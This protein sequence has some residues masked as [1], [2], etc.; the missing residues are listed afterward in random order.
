MRH[1][2]RTLAF[3]LIFAAPAFAQVAPAP[4]SPAAS[5]PAAT[6]KSLRVAVIGASASAGFGCV[7]REKRADGDY[8]LGF[9]LI[10]MIRI[11]C[12]EL[13]LVTT[14][15]S[16][17][18]FFLSPVRNGATAAKRAVDFKP[19]CVVA[20]DFLFWYCYGDDAPQGGRLADEG[21]RLAK[22][23]LGLKELEK[24]E[25]PVLVGD[26]P[27]MSPAVG[28]MLSRAQM[29]AK[30]SLAKANARFAEWAKGRANV[31]VLPLADMQRQLMTDHALEIRGVRLTATPQAP[32]LQVDELHPAPLGMAGLA[33]AVA[34]EMKDALATA[35][36]EA[37]R[38]DCAPE[39]NSTIQR[40]S[41]AL[42]PSGV[43]PKSATPAKTPT[44]PAPTAPA[45]TLSAAR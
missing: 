39:P 7:M 31:R 43:K 16:S 1:A 6:K 45:S 17:G 34:A 15:M 38:D 4:A 28:K 8:A 12:P 41:A 18:F 23:E 42:K 14:D 3:T 19:D 10:D 2:L 29:P 13:E 37:P 11:A 33:C 9:R 35:K 36:S 25:V 27:D 24:F 26:L 44:A 5:A 40:A 22:L 30:D 32:L 20:L 21:E